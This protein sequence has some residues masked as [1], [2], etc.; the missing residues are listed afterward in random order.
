M[1]TEKDMKNCY[2]MQG[3]L[4]SK[5]VLCRHLVA[6]CCAGNDGKTPLSELGRCIG[7]LLA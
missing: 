1:R 3:E 6:G 7:H 2:P 4:I 5:P